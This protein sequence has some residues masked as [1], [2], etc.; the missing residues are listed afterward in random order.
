MIGTRL[1]RA[2]ARRALTLIEV[3][4]VIAILLA[5]GGLVAYNLLPAREQAIA[6]LQL[7]DIDTIRAALDRFRLDMN[8]YPTEEE[9]LRALLTAD[10]LENEN[11]QTRWRGP[12]LDDSQAR[13]DRDRWGNAFIYRNPSEVRGEG[14]IDIVSIGP[15][16]EEGTDDDV[17]NH[18]R[19]RGADGEIESSDIDDVRF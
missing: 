1:A 15:D 17:T 19:L 13:P 7:R 3:L 10:A 16:G 12:Y 6:D 2:A 4:I 18:D 8:R 14:Y 9:G 11:D 5:I